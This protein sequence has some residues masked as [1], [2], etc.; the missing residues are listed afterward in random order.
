M[1]K[2]DL[3]HSQ[4]N[5]FNDGFSQRGGN[6]NHRLDKKG[7]IKVGGYSTEDLSHMAIGATALPLIGF[8]GY[9]AYQALKQR[10]DFQN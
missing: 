9:K 4:S 8:A 10:N 7:T 1:N 6:L 5:S 3:V 2:A